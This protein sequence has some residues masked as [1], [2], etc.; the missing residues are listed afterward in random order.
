MLAY[1]LNITRNLGLLK[2]LLVMF[3]V[4]PLQGLCLAWPSDAWRIV[5]LDHGLYRP[6]LLRMVIP[7]PVKKNVDFCT[8]YPLMFEHPVQDIPQRLIV[9][10]RLQFIMY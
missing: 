7:K 8:Y 1:I 10:M 4:P 2:Q 6:A 5:Q 3:L 9:M